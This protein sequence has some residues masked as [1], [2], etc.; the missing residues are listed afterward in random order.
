MFF[1][2]YVGSGPSE[3]ALRLRSLP[4]GGPPLG[5]KFSELLVKI[6]DFLMEIIII[7]WYWPPVNF[8]QIWTTIMKNIKM[9]IYFQKCVG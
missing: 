1:Q 2:R 6:N 4:E 9:K 5:E 3:T 8:D 7:L